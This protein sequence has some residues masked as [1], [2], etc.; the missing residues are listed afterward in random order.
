MPQETLISREEATAAGFK[1]AKDL[2]T[3]QLGGNASGDFGL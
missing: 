3:L 2:L 1:A